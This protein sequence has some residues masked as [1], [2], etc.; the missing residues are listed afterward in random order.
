MCVMCA[1]V[2]GTSGRDNV[3]GYPVRIELSAIPGG[4]LVTSTVGLPS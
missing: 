1:S 2:S 4:R 3:I